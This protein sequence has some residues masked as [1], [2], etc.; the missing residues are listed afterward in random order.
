MTLNHTGNNLD[1]NTNTVQAKIIY[2]KKH[3]VFQMQENKNLLQWSRNRT[4]ESK[5]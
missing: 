2:N 4:I 3:G 5:M 1:K